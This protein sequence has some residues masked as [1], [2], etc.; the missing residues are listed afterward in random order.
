MTDHVDYELP[1]GFLGDLVHMVWVRRDVESIFAY[2]E[3]I[4]RQRFF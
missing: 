4:I 2:R 3:R 1:F